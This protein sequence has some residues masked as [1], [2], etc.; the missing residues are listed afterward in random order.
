MNYNHVLVSITGGSYNRS[1]SFSAQNL[2]EP[3]LQK[4]NPI[5]VN[6]S[7]DN[8]T[9]NL[10][11]KNNKIINLPLPKDSQDC[12]NKQYVDNELNN[13]KDKELKKLY[14]LI[15]QMNMLVKADDLIRKDIK[16][17]KDKLIKTHNDFDN[18]IE[19]KAIEIINKI[20]SLKINT[21]SFINFKEKIKELLK[22]KIDKT[23]VDDQIK[24]V[25]N[26]LDLKFHNELKETKNEIYEK[27]DKI[28]YDNDNIKYPYQLN[29]ILHIGLSD[30]ESFIE[31]IFD[32]KNGD[33]KKYI[34]SEKQISFQ[35]TTFLDS[36]I[37][38]DK[39]SSNIKSYKFYPKYDVLQIITNTF[40]CSNLTW[41]LKAKAFLV[42]NIYE[43]E[44]LEWHPSLT[45]NDYKNVELHS[46]K[47]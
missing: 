37:Y 32:I 39:L 8:M 33:F 36:E 46:I 17:L 14:K 40:R 45:K 19:S 42:I 30:K 6:Q 16:D 20:D 24:F 41:G 7:G 44:V 26:E 35:I 27:V 9:G 4:T 18:L 10:D 5:F 23:Y 31:S 28:V 38:H 13:I 11:M 15:V 25:K 43:S 12:C 22:T 29:Y 47:I 34:K 21:D 2:L 1:P 3:I